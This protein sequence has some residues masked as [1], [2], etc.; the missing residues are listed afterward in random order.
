MAIHDRC[1]IAPNRL[2]V[3]KFVHAEINV[4][5]LAREMRWHGTSSDGYSG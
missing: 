1:A 4:A 5:R 3:Y 2:L